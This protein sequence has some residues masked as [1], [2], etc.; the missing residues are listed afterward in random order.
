[1][2]EENVKQGGYGDFAECKHISAKS[3]PEVLINLKDSLKNSLFLLHFNDVL[4]EECDWEHIHQRYFEYRKRK[5]HIG[6]LLC[7][8]Y[9]PSPLG[10]GVIKE[11][12]TDT[13][14]SFIEKPDQ[15]VGDNLANLAVAIF[16]PDILDY[17]EIEHKGLFEDTIGSVI[18]AKRT[19]SLYRVEKWHHVQDLKSLYF[20]QNEADLGF[21]TRRYT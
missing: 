9:Y 11:G 3:V 4:I 12:Q 5:K 1:A 20:L 16:E 6:M 17:L 10:I 14:S 21:L 2:I 19:I 15:L 7:S 13:L 8:K 18:N